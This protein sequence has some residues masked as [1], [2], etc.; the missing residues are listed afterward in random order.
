MPS[1][2]QP[3]QL[4]MSCVNA[5]SD[6]II[7]Q[8]LL[9][10]ELD[11][12]K[13]IQKLLYRY[14]PPVVIQDVLPCVMQLLGT[15]YSPCASP[16]IIS[17][18][19]RILL[20]P[21]L[22]EVQLSE[23]TYIGNV[24]HD[25]LDLFEAALIKQLPNMSQ[26]THLD[27]STHRYKTT[28]PS[29]SDEI[30]QVLGLHC[31]S[32]RVLNLNFN[33]R[34]TGS[35]LN[36][37]YPSKDH[38]GCEKLERLFVQDCSIQ[39]EDVAMVLC[40]FSDLELVGYKELGTSIRMLKSR[41]LF[42]KRTG[43]LKLTH[44]DN[45]L[46]GVQRDDGDIVRL[47]VDLCPLMENL[48]VRVCDD[49]LNEIHKLKNLKHL[50][51][52]YYTGV[53]HPVGRCSELYL[54][55]CGSQLTSF[56]IYCSTLLSRHILVIAESCVN[57]KKLFVHA[58]M[59][60]IDEPLDIDMNKLELLEMLNLRLGDDELVMNPAACAFVE[61]L[62]RKSW[63]LQELYL[64]VRSPEFHHSFISSLVQMN[65]LSHLKNLIIDVPRRTL[66]APMLEL[67]E[68]TACLLMDTCDKLKILG[69]LI[70]WDV[71]PEQVSELR[72]TSRARNYNLTVIYAQS[73]KLNTKYL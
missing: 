20:H 51:V 38:P 72:S 67:S 40:S 19:L 35:G 64:M 63:K 46:S 39:P 9:C 13:S 5:T 53:H 36:Y 42:R 43:C 71:T 10:P 66:A 68:E 69:N 33:N 34:V 15:L 41:S 18:L 25:S 21:R 26:L 6:M 1:Q 54:R 37:L 65:P 23:L 11:R 70:C 50:E 61:F 30:L 62:V 27:L 45:T 73:N 24:E 29:C 52:R 49:N 57:L 59:A 28:F 17:S 7:N 60:E 58:N 47:L 16:E 31:P 56:T 22:T 12:E 55:T 4:R 44:L 2:R 48:K 32:L 3:K 8:L 14:A